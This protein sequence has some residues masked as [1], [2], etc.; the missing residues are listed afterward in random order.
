MKQREL[1]DFLKVIEKLKCNTRHS[2]TSTGR[3][4]SV[5]EHSWRLS[6]MALLL[7]DEFPGIDI[8][9]V[10]RMCLIHDF[11]EALT[12]DIPAFLKTARD[13]ENEELAIRRL[14]S[15]LPSGTEAEFTALFDEMAMLDTPE[16]KLYK[17]L[18]KMET[19]ISHNEAPIASW[20][21]LEYEQ[22]LS[23]GESNVA[24]SEY[25]M[26]LKEQINRDTISKIEDNL[27]SG[28]PGKL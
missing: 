28:M 12:G 9:K 13:E 21:P 23:Y 3:H 16:A 24:H 15:G 14:L 11:G 18:D 2:W 17:A 10:I 27:R 4:E 20:L 6:V 19:I 5:A 22:N 7:A 25:L 1:I 26:E 8:N